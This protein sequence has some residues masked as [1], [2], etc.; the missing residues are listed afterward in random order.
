MCSPTEGRDAGASRG[1]TLLDPGT[2]P[3][4][5]HFTVRSARG[6]IFAPCTPPGSHRPRLARGCV[7]RYSSPSAPRGPH[8][9]SPA[10]R[11]PTR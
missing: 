6:V 5:P 4:P 7:R 10:P 8:G 2:Y 3:R 11:P 1:T 9:S